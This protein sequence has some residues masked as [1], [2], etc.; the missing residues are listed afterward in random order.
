MDA[1]HPVYVIDVVAE[2]LPFPCEKFVKFFTVIVPLAI[3]Y[4]VLDVKMPS[5]N[6]LL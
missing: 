5:H 6:S 2:K 1:E 4:W 3:P